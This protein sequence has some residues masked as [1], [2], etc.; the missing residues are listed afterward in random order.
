MK[1]KKSKKHPKIR[2]F[3]KIFLSILA[4][5]FAIVLGI[6]AGVVFGLF[7]TTSQLNAEDLQLNFTTLVYA[8]DDEGNEVEY[9]RLYDQQNR[10]WVD[11]ADTPQHLKDAFVAI[12]DERFYQHHG[13]DFKSTSY[14]AWGYITK[15]STARGGSTITQQLVK[16][17]TGERETTPIRKIKEMVRAMNLEQKMSKDQI[18]ELY[19][20]TIYLSQGCYGVGSASHMYFGKDVSE[21]TLAEAASI[22]GITQYPTR[23]DPLQ[24]PENNKE[25]QELVLQKMLELG[26][27]SQEEHDEAVAQELVFESSAEEQLASRQSY[28]V[29]QVISDV[30]EDLEEQKGYSETRAA[31]LLYTGGLKI[32]ATVDPTVQDI[33]TEVYQNSVSFPAYR[34]DPA[35]QSAMVIIDPKNGQVKG[36]VGGLGEKSGD[37]VLNRATQSKRQPG[38]TIK[39]IAVYAP[40]VEDDLIGEATAYYDKPVTY[41]NWSPKNYYNSFYGQMTVRRA[42]EISANT[43]PVQIL[44]EL[45][46]T[47][48]YSFMTENLGFTSLVEADKSLASLGLGGLTYGV[49]VMEMASAYAAFANEG[50]Y[51]R[52]ITYTKVLDHNGKVLLEN[53]APGQL[54]MSE[55]TAYIMNSL[56]RG[57]VDYGTGAAAK[58]TGK[59]PI[60]GK[61]G[62]TDDD[63]DR[64]F[65]GYTPHYVGAV[66]YGFDNPKSVAFLNS[67]PTIPPWKTVM[68]RIDSAKNLPSASFKR[69]GGLYD[70]TVCNT[71]GLLAGDNC[72]AVRNVVLKNGTG[73]KEVCTSHPELLTVC[74]ASKALAGEGCPEDQTEKTEELP[75]GYSSEICL[76]HNE[77][78]PIESEAP[79]PTEEP[80]ATPGST[81]MAP[82]TPPPVQTPPPATSRR[83]KPTPTP[84]PEG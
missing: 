9:E 30:L 70:V 27:I 45:G 18:L 80:T 40:A 26:M 60:C 1:R 7:D 25:K 63:K 68:Q 33:M 46:V 24:N 15:R 8:V 47:R 11:I 73:S 67:N 82:T 19:I 16:N 55:Q 4:V 36:L 38:S 35:P 79:A 32:Y 66:W 44:D 23:Y 43:V 3:L 42:V 14:A 75:E 84:T 28:F 22:A 48:S 54:A 53:E 29:D 52:P 69:P 78:E 39:P 6:T 74:H 57:V 71:T 5:G 50:V 62:T 65:I 31:K 56:L 13:V 10:V 41:R 59:Y 51:H 20:N 64:W 83:P 81:M 72:S 17:L 12:E 77:P 58:Y 61:T 34:G 37:R 76:L 49:T 2:L 21:L